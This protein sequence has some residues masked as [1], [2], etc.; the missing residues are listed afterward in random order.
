VER[1]YILA[2]VKANKGNKVKA[3]GQL[4]IGAATLYRKL[5][6]YEAQGLEEANP[7]ASGA[8]A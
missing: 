2:A 3:A 5:A 7:L 1:D 4:R 8:E 6:Q